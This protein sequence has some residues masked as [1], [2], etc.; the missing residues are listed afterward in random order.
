MDET[1]DARTLLATLTDL[2]GVYRMLDAQGTVL[3]VGKAKNLKKRVASYFRDN[4][5]SPRTALM[6]SQVARVETTTTRSEA[7]ALLSE[8]ITD[9]SYTQRGDALSDLAERA[10]LEVETLIEVNCLT[11]LLLSVGQP[12][13]VPLAAVPRTPTPPSAPPTNPPPPAPTSGGT[14][15]DPVQPSATPQGPPTNTPAPEPPTET[16]VTDPPTATAPAPPPP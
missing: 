14:T 11:S 8:V 2:P 13:W 4:H 1:F 16:P 10:N 12:L 6:V 3:Y 7:E 5:P 9:P 15:P